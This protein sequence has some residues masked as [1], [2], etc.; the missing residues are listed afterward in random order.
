MYC[1]SDSDIPQ[2]IRN[3]ISRDFADGVAAATAPPGH[4][5]ELFVKFMRRDMTHRGFVYKRGL[6]TDTVPF[7][8]RGS[9]K[10]GG[11]YFSR[12]E[13]FEKWRDFGPLVAFVRVPHG[14]AV[15]EEPCGTKLKASAIEI[16]DIHD[17][18]GERAG[19][20]EKFAE[21]VGSSV[22]ALCLAAVKRSGWSIRCVPPLARTPELCLAAVSR[23]GYSLKFIPV[24]A[25][26]PEICLAAVKRFYFSLKYA[27]EAAH[28][29]ELYT[30]AVTLSGKALAF[31][32]ETARTVELC[33]AA[34]TRSGWEALRFVPEAART[35][36][37]L[38]LAER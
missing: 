21:R 14:A 3:I 24:A 31:V 4:S 25:R 34:V 33:L 5:G 12:F 27:P 28:T 9:C 36:D 1:D 30:T 10:A 29:P 8:G 32:P 37:I 2:P 13:D 38:L 17:A 16:V 15:Y 20:I 6:N 35:P 11:L 26:T 7:N 18:R 22:A 19:W 23:D